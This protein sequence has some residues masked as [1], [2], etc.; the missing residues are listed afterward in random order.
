METGKIKNKQK[1]NKTRK[2]ANQENKFTKIKVGIVEVDKRMS[3][4]EK[5][6][7]NKLDYEESTS[8]EEDV[9]VKKCKKEE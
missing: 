9:E 7:V 4:N 6:I 8:E 5:N 1:Q 2:S 3:L